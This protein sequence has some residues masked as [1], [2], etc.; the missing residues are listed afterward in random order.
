MDDEK[1]SNKL[2]VYTVIEIRRRIATG[3]Q[4]HA[5][6]SRAFGIAKA[7]VTDIKTGKNWGWVPDIEHSDVPLILGLVYEGMP[8]AEIA[9]KF[10]ADVRSMRKVVIHL[11]RDMLNTYQ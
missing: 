7:S 4:S 9:E 11:T 10:D 8:L 1:P 2:T 3:E 5:Q 6:I